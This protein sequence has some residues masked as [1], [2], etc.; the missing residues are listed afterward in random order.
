MKKFNKKMILPV[1]V[2]SAILL[3]NNNCSKDEVSPPAANPV[4][5]LTTTDISSI[6]QA[7]ATSGGNITNNG[8]T[9]I[10]A[11]GVCWSTGTTPSIAGS[12]TTDGSGNGS[13]TS[14]ITGLSPNTKYYVRAYATNSTGTG[15]GSFRSFTTLPQSGNLPVVSTSAV[16]N[17][18][19]STA[20]C[21]GNVTFDC[22][23]T[24]TVR[25][26]CWST[27]STPTID[28]SKTADGSGLG[29][30]TSALTG[31][32]P[33]TTYFVRAYATNSAGT[34]YGSAVSFTTITAL[35]PVLTTSPV[36]NVLQTMA[37][38]GGNITSDNGS[39]I[40]E[41]GL[42]WSTG[43]T[44]TINDSKTIDVNIGTGSFADDVTGCNPNTKYYVR[45]YASN[46]AGT[47]YGNA[48]AFT[49]LSVLP[50][51][52][53]TD[54][55]GNVYNSIIIGSQ[56]WMVSN[57][58]TTKYKDGTAIP[59]VTDN[60][61]WTKLTNPGYCWYNNDAA[62][63]KSKY[64]A[65]YNGHAID[66]KKLCPN[67][68]HVPTN[69]E[70]ATLVN[71][72]GGDTIAGGKLKETGTVH[73]KTPNSGA[74]N[75]IGFGALPGGYRIIND[76]TFEGITENGYWWSS[77]ELADPGRSR[78]MYYM[79]EGVYRYGCDGITGGFSV[80]CLKD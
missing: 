76:G 19:K 34:G 63:N 43:T 5:V 27:G 30:Y 66:T 58:K 35:P 74:T 62:A 60:T 14:A 40:T 50:G 59:L 48:I 46:I 11:R 49:T 31:L 69:T 64:G 17:I 12:K 68:W 13:F 52:G 71:A 36:S 2:M 9:A 15:Y 80:R 10:I 41:R 61:E 22:G 4:P 72:L 32:I 24:V 38:S 57:L 3:I 20:S 37:T 18:T 47:S 78:G 70:W 23:L 65:L 45:A 8:G 79:G 55:D 21:G 54:I 25:G 16:S 33:G 26:V 67:G 77:T 56:E 28:D 7:S 51:S 6:S 44:P 73:W 53:T 42:C 39:A 29:N 1:I 75:S